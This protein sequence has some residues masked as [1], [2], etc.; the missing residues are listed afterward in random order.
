MYR[1]T[2]ELSLFISL[3][4]LSYQNNCDKPMIIKLFD[5]KLNVLFHFFL[6]KLFLIRKPKIASTLKPKRPLLEKY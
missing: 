6:G 1:V 2:N 4:F 3:A 5:V